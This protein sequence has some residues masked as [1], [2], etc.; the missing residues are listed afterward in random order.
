MMGAGGGPQQPVL[1]LK[2]N[3][4]RQSGRK[5]Q[6]ANIAA[7]RVVSE[8]IRTTLGPKSMLK[9]ILDP[10]GGIVMTNDGN[11]ILR[12]L[13]VSQP[14]A[15]SIIELSRAQD[16]E[17]G[18]G[19]TSVVVLAG[20]MLS[21]GEPFLLRNTHPTVIVQ[22]YTKALEDAV[23]LMKTFATKVDVDNDEELTKVVDTCLNTK[24]VHGFGSR[25]SQL[26]IDSVRCVSVKHP[27]GKREIDIK[28][29][30]RVEKIPGGT[31]EESTVLKGVMVNKDVTHP[32]MAREI[33]NPKVLLLDCPLE[34]KKGESQTN[35]EVTKE[36]DW[37]KLLMQEEEEV[38]KMCDEIIAVK[39]DVVFTEKGVSDLAQ[40][41]LMK[42]KISVIRRVRKTD[43]NRMAKVTG[44][45]VCNRNLCM[46][47]AAV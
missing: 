20:E 5:A 16:E 12:E 26:A 29:Y 46:A 23:A 30:V 43:N 31:W 14:A 28:R 18:D 2:P 38:R 42:A 24:F 36:E 6:L 10:M 3:V 37:E 41:F 40:H 17:V 11:A 21:A 34:Y 33:K 15:K 25:L 35:V 47:S 4:K 7:G 44:A 39:P 1:V 22:G 45:T 19:T 27:S 32:K 8:V 13:E 9:M